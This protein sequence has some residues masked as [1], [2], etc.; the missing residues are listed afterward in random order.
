MSEGSATND[1]VGAP[2][3]G[4]YQTTVDSKFRLLIPQVL[5]ER[6]GDTFAMALS[7][8]GCITVMPQS[9]FLK[10]WGEIQQ[11]GSLNPARRRYARDF[12]RYAA[13]GLSFDGQGRVVI[14]SYLRDKGNLVK[15]VLLIG[16]GD[17]V[18][19]WSPSEF[20]IYM[21]NEDGYGGERQER[22]ESAYLAMKEG[23]AE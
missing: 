6:L 17:V 5:R 22:M 16:A 13:D 10:K 14:P 7:E 8:Y 21:E 18:E 20:D 4:E 15:E 19:V 2:L 12:M 9:A 11:S 23:G 3:Y 1:L